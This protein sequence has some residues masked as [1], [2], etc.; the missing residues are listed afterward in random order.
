MYIYTYIHMY[1]YIDY[2]YAIHSGIACIL[3]PIELGGLR[4]TPVARFAV[5]D[6]VAIY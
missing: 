4:S 1:I 6:K 3:T 2:L 5:E